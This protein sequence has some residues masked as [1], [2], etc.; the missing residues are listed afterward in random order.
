MSGV[1]QLGYLGFEVSD[2][3]SW[4]HFASEVLGLGLVNRQPNGGFGLRMDGHSQRFF[5]EPG[6]ADDVSFI[7]WELEDAASLEQTVTRLRD[8]GVEV[9]EV[10]GAPRR[11]TQRYALL[12][13]AGM[14]TELYWGPELSS[15]SF[16]SAQMR[17]GFVADAQGLGHVVVSAPDVTASEEFYRGLLG[18]RL[19]DHIVTEYYG[20][21]VNLA[22]FHANSRHH[23]VAFGGP[24]E[25]R[26]HHFMLEVGAI[27][28]VGLALDRALKAGITL[29]QTLGRHP[30]DRML[31]FYALTPSGFSFEVGWGGAQVDEASWQP[32]TYDCVSEWG[33]HPPQ[34]LAPRRKK[35][36]AES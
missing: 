32:T 34:V 5:V 20:F 31:S 27:D 30:N 17:S 8:A 26:I 35:P 4:E 18:F 10:D 3:P 23:S 21:P 29:T 24:Q 36:G 25:K 15:E 2:L 6:P 28:D 22:F 12:D 9:E 7:G 14:P 19:S 16:R 11:V 33:H 13:P 1:A